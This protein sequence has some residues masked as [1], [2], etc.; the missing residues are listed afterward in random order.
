MQGAPTRYL[1]AAPV[2]ALPAWREGVRPVLLLGH[3]DLPGM[4]FREEIEKHRSGLV[5]PVSSAQLR[6]TAEEVI[7]VPPV[8]PLL[9]RRARAFTLVYARRFNAPAALASPLPLGHDAA[10]VHVV[11]PPYLLRDYL[12]A[13]AGYFL[14]AP[15]RP[16]A[17]RVGDSAAAV[18]F[19][20]IER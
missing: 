11:A 10:F 20:L 3:E 1:G 15:L 4:E 6:G 19:A 5:G 2:L 18:A 16:I 7:E 9:P 12:A 8:G 17:P 13:H 14:R